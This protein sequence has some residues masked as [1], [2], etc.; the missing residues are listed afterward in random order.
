MNPV[1]DMLLS[2]VIKDVFIG[3]G[4]KLP[5]GC[6]ICCIILFASIVN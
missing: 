6:V 5:W 4:M 3:T 1:I 2:T